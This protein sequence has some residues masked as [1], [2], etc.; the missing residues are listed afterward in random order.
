MQT[1]KLLVPIATDRIENNKEVF[2]ATYKKIYDRNPRWNYNMDSKLACADN[3]VSFDN[4]LLVAPTQSQDLRK[5]AK[6]LGALKGSAYCINKPMFD[7]VTN[8]I[9]TK[10]QQDYFAKVMQKTLEN[11]VRMNLEG[12]NA[13]DADELIQEDYI[14]ETNGPEEGGCDDDVVGD[15]DDGSESIHDSDTDV[16]TLSQ[17]SISSLPSLYHSS[18]R[19]RPRPHGSPSRK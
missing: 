8:N 13:V 12:D 6:N 5:V 17:V 9:R 18:T 19:K 1:F 2:I 14:G 15:V 7:L 4:N 16:R 10:K 3:D 11:L